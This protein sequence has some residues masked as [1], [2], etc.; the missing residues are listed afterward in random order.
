MNRHP[1]RLWFCL[2]AFAHSS[3]LPMAAM[4]HQKAAFT[5]CSNRTDVIET[6]VYNFIK[7]EAPALI[8]FGQDRT[9][10]WL[11]VRL[12]NPQSANQN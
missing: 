6:G 4:N 9:E 12:K 3:P 1:F 11:L 5:V 10:Q 2:V 8:H 7:E